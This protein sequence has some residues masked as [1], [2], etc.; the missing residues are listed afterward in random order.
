MRYTFPLTVGLAAGFGYAVTAAQRRKGWGPATIAGAIVG[1]GGIPG[2][3]LRD[4]ATLTVGMVGED[5]RD[6]AGRSLRADPQ[7]VG[8]ARDPWYWSATLVPDGANPRRQLWPY[9]QGEI[10]ASASPPI[11]YPTT[12]EATQT[13][14]DPRVFDAK[15]AR[16]ALSNFEVDYPERLRGRRDLPP[17]VAGRVAA[18]NAWVDRLKAEYGPETVF[19]NGSPYGIED[20]DYVRPVVT[21]WKRRTP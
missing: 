3:G 17:D 15:P 21:I 11:V 18:A 8:L 16:I 6:A 9:L 20:M 5:P 4:A 19:A 10:V 12:P 1:L 14:F 13:Y 2:G 7:P